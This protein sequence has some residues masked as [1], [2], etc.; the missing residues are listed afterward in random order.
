MYIYIIYIYA[1]IYIYIYI[2]LCMSI[3]NV[4]IYIKNKTF[5]TE[6]V[7]FQFLPKLQRLLRRF[8]RNRNM[9]P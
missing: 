6:R 1:Y 3:F 7:I 5:I 8:R 9:A 2:K 4:N